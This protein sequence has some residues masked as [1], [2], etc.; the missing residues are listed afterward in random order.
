[1][2]LVEQPPW[3]FVDE[4]DDLEDA[5]PFVYDFDDVTSIG[6]WEL[7]WLLR[8]WLEYLQKSGV[9]L[10]QYG[11]KEADLYE[12]GLVSWNWRLHDYLDMDV[13]LTN[14]TWGPSLSDWKVRVE[15]HVIEEAPEMPLK[16]LVK[17]PGGLIEDD[18]SEG[19]RDLWGEWENCTRC[20]DWGDWGEWGECGECGECGRWREW[21]EWGEWGVMGEW[22]DWGKWGECGECGMWG[23]WGRWRKWGEGEEGEEEEEGE[24]GE[25]GE[26]GEEGENGESRD[27]EA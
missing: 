21:S 1:M 6:P 8:V 17:M 26:E 12:Q 2:V 5:R 11:Q 25:K 19:E 16:T 10:E 14:L 24:K 18:D 15:F 22:G 23:G 27:S 4:I 20:R 13:F 7:R 9:D 3:G